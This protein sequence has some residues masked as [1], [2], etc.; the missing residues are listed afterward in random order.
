MKALSALIVL[1]CLSC[2][3][4]DCSESSS[5]RSN[6]EAVM[7]RHQNGK[8]SD[9]FEIKDCYPSGIHIDFHDNGIIAKYG[10]HTK[11]GERSLE[12][13]VY[14]TTGM[15]LC[16]QTYED[17]E[18]SHVSTIDRKVVFF[19]KSE[20]IMNSTKKTLELKNDSIV[21]RTPPEDFKIYY[22]HDTIIFEAGKKIFKLDNNLRILSTGSS[23]LNNQGI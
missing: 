14:D 13:L 10:Y 4:N 12:W 21:K 7:Y 8:P 3:N 11:G 22:Q 16:K 15:L 19:T 23:D 20:R 9:F 17:G 2:T 1:L 6:V 18:V 5:Y